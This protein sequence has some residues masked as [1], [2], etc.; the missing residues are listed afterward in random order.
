VLLRKSLKKRKGA[1]MVEYALLVAGVALIGAGA[2]SVMGKKT[3]DMI[4]LVAAVLPG[5]HADDN[6]P[7]QSGQ[8]IETAAT[9][10]GALAVNVGK[11]ASETGV[12]R[13][14]QNVAGTAGA[15]DGV[16]GLL[17]EPPQ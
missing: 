11:I 6:A 15:T 4:G 12:D 10:N 14:G 8:L 1:A 7:I 16:G 5:A 17:V 2:V 3:G 9:T 13:L